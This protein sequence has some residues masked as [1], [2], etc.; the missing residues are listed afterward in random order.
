[1]P[2]LSE[3]DVDFPRLRGRDENGWHVR[4]EG[5][6]RDHRA[7]LQK[8]RVHFAVPVVLCAASGTGI[9]SSVR[10]RSNGHSLACLCLGCLLLT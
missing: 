6:S 4:L 2:R 8:A 3:I 5:S 10:L 1:M 9:N 7:L